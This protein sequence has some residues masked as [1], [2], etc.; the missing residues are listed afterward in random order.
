VRGEGGRFFLFEKTTCPF[1][2]REKGRKRRAPSHLFP[3]GAKGK[4]PSLWGT[5]PFRERKGRLL[6]I[7]EEEKKKKTQDSNPPLIRWRKGKKKDINSFVVQR[8]KELRPFNEE[9]KKNRPLPG[10]KK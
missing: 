4:S 1:L 10:A 2:F 5:R 7:Q 3:R 6:P 8:K 9:S